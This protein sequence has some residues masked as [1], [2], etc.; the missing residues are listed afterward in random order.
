MKSGPILLVE[1]NSDDEALTIRALR[2]ANIANDIRVA[3]DGAEAL[4]MLFGSDKFFPSIVLLDLK[5]PKVGGIEVLQRIRNEESTRR[6]NVVVLTSSDEGS[7]IERT[8]DL[9][10]NSYVRKPVNFE[11]F[12]TAV[13]QVG[14]YWLLLNEPPPERHAV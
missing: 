1:D 7:D 13:A 2:K 8:Y 10:V 3:R 6:L 14:M 12:A 9:H 5:L 4:D 11:D